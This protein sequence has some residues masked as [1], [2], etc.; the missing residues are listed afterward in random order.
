MRSSLAV[1]SGDELRRARAEASSRARALRLDAEETLADSL[2]SIARFSL[3]QLRDDRYPAVFEKL[4]RELPAL[5]WKSVR[6][7]TADVDLARK[8]FPDAEISPVGHIS[9]GVEVTMADGA[10]RVIN[11]FE[12]EIGTFMGRPAS[13]DGQ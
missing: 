1:V 10:I 2:Y 6:V 12:K 13:A 11:T 3:H 4:V 7:N 9:G 8:Y 5:Q